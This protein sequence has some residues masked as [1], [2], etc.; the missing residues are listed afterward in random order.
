VRKVKLFIASSLDSY[1]ARSDGSVDWLFTD[2]D[3]GYAKF[4]DSIDT[5]IMGRKTYDTAL[6]F[7]KQ[8][9]KEKKSYVFTRQPPSQEFCNVE[10]VSDVVGVTRDLVHSDN[11][12][13][14]WLVG[15]AEINSILLEA[16]LIH[17]LII[18]IHP[19]ILGSGIPLFKRVR[20]VDTK[21][22]DLVKYDNGLLQVSYQL[23]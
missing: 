21:L 23:S 4:Y 20:Q 15:G 11:N 6:K 1:I 7:D 16:G 14:I 3:Y 18:A 13:D 9:Y 10:F 2:G 22:V 19:T 17:E 12:K 5:V 8:P